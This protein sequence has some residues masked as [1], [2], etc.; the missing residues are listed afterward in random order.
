MTERDNSH[1]VEVKKSG[2]RLSFYYLEEIVWEEEKSRDVE[3]S[4]SL[5]VYDLTRT[6]RRR[7]LRAAFREEGFLLKYFRR[8]G[9]SEF[10]RIV[11]CE[12]FT[13]SAS[14]DNPC[15]PA[16]KLRIIMSE[17]QYIDWEDS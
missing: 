4:A 13:T 17:D 10:A 5:N 9:R 11:N 15:K 7:F 1:L 6:I 12:E 8:D 16:V 14:Q 2:S 3:W